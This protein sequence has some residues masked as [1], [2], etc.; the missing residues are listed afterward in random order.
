MRHFVDP[1]LAVAALRATPLR[2]LG[3]LEFLGFLFESMVIRDL[4]IYAQAADAE[5]F[6]YREKEGL[7]VDAVV[8]A[9]DGRWAAFEIKLGERWV[10]DGARNLLRLARRMEQSDH[11]Q[12]SALAVI[13]PSGYGS[14]GPGRRGSDPRRHDGALTA[15]PGRAIVLKERLATTARQARPAASTR[16]AQAF[17]QL[18]LLDLSRW[19]TRQF[20]HDFEAFGRLLP[21][22]LQRRKVLTQLLEGERLAGR[23]KFPIAGNLCRVPVPNQGMS[24]QCHR[25]QGRTPRENRSRPWTN[26]FLRSNRLPGAPG[27]ACRAPRSSGP[28][29]R[30]ASGGCPNRRRRQGDRPW[31]PTGRRATSPKPAK[32]VRVSVRAGRSPARPPR[33]ARRRRRR[34]S[35]IAEPIARPGRKNRVTTFPRSV[36]HLRILQ[37]QH[38]RK[39]DGTAYRKLLESLATLSQTVMRRFSECGGDVGSLESSQTT[40][41]SAEKAY[42]ALRQMVCRAERAGKFARAAE[43]GRALA[44]IDRIAC[45]DYRLLPASYRQDEPVCMRALQKQ[46]APAT[47]EATS[48]HIARSP[49]FV[50]PYDWCETYRR[51]HS[52]A[53]R[54]SSMG[55]HDEYADCMRIINR[56]DRFARSRSSDLVELRLYTVH[57]RSEQHYKSIER[58][59]AIKDAARRSS[60]SGVAPQ[61]CRFRTA[62]SEI[63]EMLADA[64]S[65]LTERLGPL[66]TLADQAD[67]SHTPPSHTSAPASP[68]PPKATTPGR[69]ETG[70]DPFRGL[71]GPS[72]RI[73]P[74]RPALTPGAPCGEIPLALRRA[75]VEH[76]KL[77]SAL[78]DAEA[79]LG[80]GGA[81][82]RG[83]YG[84]RRHRVLEDIYLLNDTAQELPEEAVAL[85]HIDWNGI[86]TLLRGRNVPLPSR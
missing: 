36:D 21:G 51:L 85:D 69:A 26:P 74:P 44:D 48:A 20:G 81:G 34:R 35:P 31:V 76:C 2:L 50:A 46:P 70:A 45:R 33:A 53:N 67:P 63:H 47:R 11:E 59:H 82:A 18:E 40:T 56:V 77:D 7:A 64:M 83:L 6:H 62:L 19:R 72:S 65:W 16:R 78:T 25:R 42:A 15:T 12:P 49:R 86:E 57:A 80:T 43:I 17:P 14:V 8:E 84:A 73:A 13:V 58:Y 24:F 27:Q 66:D 75:I 52:A 79:T 30:W 55:R 28:G 10:E 1:S 9:A 23:R 5:V 38:F 22:H 41:T 29:G 4:R 37:R 54:L 32:R 60:E 68:H 39:R 61:H 71:P 3:D